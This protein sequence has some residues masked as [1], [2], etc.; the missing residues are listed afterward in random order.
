MKFFLKIFYIALA[1][2]I[3][4]ACADIEDSEISLSDEEAKGEIIGVDKFSNLEIGDVFC[5]YVYDYQTRSIWEALTGEEF[6]HG[7]LVMRTQEDS[8][9]GMYFTIMLPWDALKISTGS[10]IELEVDSNLTAKTRRFVFKIPETHNTVREIKLGIT[11]LDWKGD[12]EAVNAWKI[13]I[14]TP[15]GNLVAEKQSW[16][17]S[18]KK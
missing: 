9:E 14:K 15:A 1:S 16:L 6:T 18:L 12:K 7:H 2:L 5:K 11:G 3:F 13:S 10:I 17:W 8:R 4:S